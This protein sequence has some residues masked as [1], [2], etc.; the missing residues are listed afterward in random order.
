[1]LGLRNDTER[2][3]ESITMTNNISPSDYDKAYFLSDTVEGYQEFKDGGLSHTKL[4]LFDMLEIKKDLTCLE[5][6][7]GR[8]EFLRHG[9]K[10]GAKMTGID[11]SEDAIE[12]AR[13]SMHDFP[14][15]EV[16][17]ADA[18][19]LPFASDSFD[20]V[21][22]GD[23]I[24]HMSYEDGISMLKEM[25]RVLR[26]GGFMLIHTAPNVAFTKIIYPMA[27]CMLKLISKE[28][29]ESVDR[30]LNAGGGF[31]IHEYNLFSLKKV[32]KKAGL[33]HANVWIDSDIFRSGKHN[34]TQTLCKNPLVKFIGFCGK[35]SVIKFLLGNDFYLK[36]S[37]E[38]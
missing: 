26:P 2:I 37:K 35:C 21:F 10:M 30:H 22:A 19:D 13:E 36:C 29:V 32:A 3:F 14:E 34:L 27:R 16:I 9:A 18:R 1:M 11:Y 23:V 5:V 25:Y 20:R 4:K 28:T 33:A 15:S 24:E 8:G 6:G 31:H 17:V 7:V 38:K 12:I